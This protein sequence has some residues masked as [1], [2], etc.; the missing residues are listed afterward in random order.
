MKND[1]SARAPDRPGATG[2]H[3]GAVPPQL[4]ACAPPNENCAPPKRG[5]CP[6]EIYRLGDSGAQIEVQT[7]VFLWTDTR[8]CDVFG[9]KAFFSFF[10]FLENTCFWLEKPLKFPISAEKSLAISVKTFFFIF[11]GDHL[12]SAGKTA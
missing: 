3:T 11:F 7:S 12:I 9:M 6:E 1:S 10:F 4:T 2:G 8:F 5:L